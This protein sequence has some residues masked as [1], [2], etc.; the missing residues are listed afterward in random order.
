[1]LCPIIVKELV[2]VMAIDKTQNLPERNKMKFAQRKIRLLVGARNFSLIC[3]PWIECF[4]NVTDYIP[5]VRRIACPNSIFDRVNKV[6]N[7]LNLNK[8]IF[9]FM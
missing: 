6:T 4:A 8:K 1:M 7:M 3:Q 9:S 2:L 5:L